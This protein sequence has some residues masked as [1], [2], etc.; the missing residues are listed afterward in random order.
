MNISAT[1]TTPSNW[2]S[3]STVLSPTEQNNLYSMI[4]P[5]SKANLIYRATTDGFQA[6]AFH[7]NFEYFYYY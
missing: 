6:S 2:L 7:S 5:F 1:T 3:L 4:Q